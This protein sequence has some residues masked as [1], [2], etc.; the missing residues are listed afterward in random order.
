MNFDDEAQITS[1]YY[2]SVQKLVQ[3]A[4]GAAHVYIFDH[5]LRSASANAAGA[6]VGG[7]GSA[8]QG[9]AFLVHTDYTQTSAPD[10]ITQLGE[11][12]RAND[13]WKK[14]VAEGAP[15]I[16]A[17]AMEKVKNGGRYGIINVWRNVKDTPANRFPLAV[18]DAQTVVEEDLSVFEIH[19]TDRVG[20]N[21]FAR[22]TPEHR[23]SY[24]PSMEKSE[25]LLMMQWDSE[26]ALASSK[27]GRLA[28]PQAAF[29]VEAA[30][31]MNVSFPKASPLAETPVPTPELAVGK[32]TF[33]LHSSFADPSTPEDAP[34]RRS[35]EVRCI[36]IY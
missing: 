3:E 5:N 32:P 25:A 14:N 36:V 26:G 34:D 30:K 10:R 31:G 18:C 23:W 6:K 29:A 24:Y 16:D 21:Y 1:E 20:E 17:E 22:R 28:Q 19:Y 15:L 9:P 4:T 33:C 2:S 13:T 7:G 8:V 35:I 11:A 12:A 27:V